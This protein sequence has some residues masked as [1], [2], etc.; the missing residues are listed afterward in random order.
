MIMESFVSHHQ[1]NGRIFE[2]FNVKDMIVHRSRNLYM[3]VDYCA[4]AGAAAGGGGRYSSKPGH[5][6]SIK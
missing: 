6:C 3:T 4:T 2:R 1:I 5:F